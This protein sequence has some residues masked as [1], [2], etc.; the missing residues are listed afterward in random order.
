VLSTGLA[1]VE[2]LDPAWLANL[3]PAEFRPHHGPFA[4]ES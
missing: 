4:V 2:M 3:D 1:V